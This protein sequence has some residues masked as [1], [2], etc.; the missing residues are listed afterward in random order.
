MWGHRRA[1]LGYI[2]SIFNLGISY[3]PQKWALSFF[4]GSELWAPIL[5]VVDNGVVTVL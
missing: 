1:L 5:K 2:G 3:G 4:E